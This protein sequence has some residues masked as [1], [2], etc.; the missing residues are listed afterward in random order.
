MEGVKPSLMKGRAFMIRIAFTG[1]R[2]DKLDLYNHPENEVKIRLELT[3]VITE[4]IKTTKP[5]EV[6]YFYSGGALGFDQIAFDVVERL[7]KMFKTRTIVNEVDVP[8]ENQ[9]TVWSEEEQR[10]YINMLRKANKVVRVDR[11]ENYKI[12]GLEQDIYHP[13][14]MQ[15][16]N[17]FMVDNCDILIALWNGTSGGTKNCI[18]YAKKKENVQIIY[19][20]V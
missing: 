3:K 19:L 5:N 9:Y 16:R 13:A 17:E 6:I 1:H 11:L 15:K 20:E 2:K 7:K 12:K 8:F 4:I 10:E 18:N 14:K